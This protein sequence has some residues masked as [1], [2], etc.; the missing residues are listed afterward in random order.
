MPGGDGTGPRGQ[1]AMT[2]RAAGYCAGYNAPGC[3]NPAPG[4][5]FGRGRRFFGRGRAFAPGFFQGEAP[6]AAPMPQPLSKD[7]QIQMLEQQKT[8]I[9]ESLK[10]IQKQ[11]ED[12]K[13]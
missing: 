9:E 7:Q 3:A 5:G 13:K 12:L 1:G 11:L 4:V 2:G 10:Q 6:A 8:A